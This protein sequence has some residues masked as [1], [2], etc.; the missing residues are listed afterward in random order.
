MSQNNHT[1]V[2]N[3]R[4]PVNPKKVKLRRKA[5]EDVIEF[6]QK[7]AELDKK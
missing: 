3:N 2:S 6:V 7:R 1:G 4:R 5:T